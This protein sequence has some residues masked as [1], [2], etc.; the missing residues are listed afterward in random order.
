[1]TQSAIPSAPVAPAQQPVMSPSSKEGEAS[2]ACQE[3]SENVSLVP[4]GSSDAAV[5]SKTIETK[6]VN[7]GGELS[8]QKL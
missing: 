3:A 2:S 7:A 8:L 5:T 1:M 4:A 6:D